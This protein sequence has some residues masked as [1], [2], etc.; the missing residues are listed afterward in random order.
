MKETCCHCNHKE[1]DQRFALFTG[2]EVARRGV[3]GEDS[4][5]EE[6]E[7]ASTDGVAR[8]RVIEHRSKIYML[9][10]DEEITVTSVL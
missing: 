9:D 7:E 1:I 6:E 5:D 2:V 10:N 3:C 8:V 4:D